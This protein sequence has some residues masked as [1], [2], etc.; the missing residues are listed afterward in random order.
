MEG[1][2]KDQFNQA[3]EVL[4]KYH[5]TKIMFNFP[6]NGFVGDMGHTHYRIHIHQCCP[7]C[8]DA[9]HKAGFSLSMGEGGLE[10][11]KI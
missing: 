3:I 2:T 4:A 5:T 8:T 6:R 9:L 7:A 11:T 1:L 10:I